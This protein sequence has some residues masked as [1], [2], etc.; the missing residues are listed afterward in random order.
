M[1]I[2]VVLDRKNPSFETTMC[3]IEKVIILPEKE[4]KRFR[5]NMIA[6]K[7]YIEQNRELMRYKDDGVAHT[8]LILGAGE[9]DG[10]IVES[11][12][13]SYA[14]YAGFAP[15]ISEYIRLKLNE[16]IDEI[17]K[18]GTEYTQ[19]GNYIISF[20]E[21]HNKYKVDLKCLQ[22]LF[23][24]MLLKREEV[25][26]VEYTEEGIDINFYLN[27]CPNA[28]ETELF[29]EAS[30]I[31]VLIVEPGEHPR[32]AMIDNKTEEFNRIVGGT[33]GVISIAPD[34]EIICN[35][36][37]KLEGLSGNRKIGND[38]IAGTF[39]IVGADDGAFFKSL[40]NGQIIKYEKQFWEIEEYTTEEV[41]QTINVKLY[42]M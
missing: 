38:I 40:K 30:Q 7:K 8:V 33:I 4:Y 29:P 10:V 13:S 2:N 35:D 41:E 39:I 27:Y 3:K 12:G 28:N 25:S 42:G 14:R 9:K 26:D 6:D 31:N 34:A 21:I 17:I 15:N 16:M 5:E 18:E 23:N 11:E 37:G 1:Y 36:N 24:D 32:R 20:E 19:E 22:E